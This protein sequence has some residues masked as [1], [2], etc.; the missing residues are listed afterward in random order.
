MMGFKRKDQKHGG[1]VAPKKRRTLNQKIVRGA[2]PIDGENP[3]LEEANEFYDYMNKLKEDGA[4][5][6]DMCIKQIINTLKSH[7]AVVLEHGHTCKLV[8]EL[9]KSRKDAQQLFLQNLFENNN[10]DAVTKVFFEKSASYTLESWLRTFATPIPEGYVDIIDKFVQYLNSAT[11]KVIY[12]PAA[13]NLLRCILELI[14]ITSKLRKEKSKKVKITL[15]GKK[16]YDKLEETHKKIVDSFLFGEFAFELKDFAEHSYLIQD[17]L[18]SCRFSYYDSIKNYFIHIWSNNSENAIISSL[19][20]QNSSP[21][22][23]CFIEFLKDS[24]VDL[25]K[26]LLKMNIIDLSLHNIANFFVGK[27]LLFHKSISSDL[28]ESIL[29]NMDQFIKGNYHNILDAILSQAESNSS[30]KDSLFK[31]FKEKYGKPSKGIFYAKFL[32][33]GSEDDYE[34]SSDDKLSFNIQKLT[35]IKIKCMKTFFKLQ[36]S[37]SSQFFENL[38]DKCLMELVGNRQG[39]ALLECFIG[40]FV[41]ADI[42]ADWL[43]EK[44]GE[45]LEQL[46][47]GKSSVFVFLALWK[48][49]LSLGKREEILKKIVE[50]KQ[51]SSAQHK[52]SRLMNDINYQMYLENKKAW[53]RKYTPK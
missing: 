30:F 13:S 11:Q 27:F 3:T 21:V 52:Y 4:T 53:S 23:E 22:W 20:N 40:Q 24:D 14:A 7:E 32:S 33:G 36:P 34:I 31:W 26:T 49:N 51:K 9:F 37:G 50:C 29:P 48:T 44:L 10:E 16:K 47:L 38:S 41:E 2:V 35:P 19:K 6:D 39:T 5:S 28:F 8:E 46:L 45:N 15:E 17:V 18:K 12:N 1:Y 43:I 42:G 25:V